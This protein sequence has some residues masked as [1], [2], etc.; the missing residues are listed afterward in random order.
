MIKKL[1]YFAF[2]LI[3]FVLI[4]AIITS[5]NAFFKNI[6]ETLSIWLYYVYPSI[7]TFYILASILISLNIINK[8]ALIF[9]PFISFDTNKAY[10]LFLI[11]I[12]IGNPISSLLTIK[13]L[14]FKKISKNDANKLIQVCSFFN[15][16]FII[17]LFTVNSIL[18]IRYAYIIIIIIFLNNLIF[19][20]IVKNKKS[21]T[22]YNKSNE[23]IFHP[24]KILSSIND[25]LYLLIQVAGV[26]VFVNIIKF[27]IT[28][29]INLIGIKSFI[30]N[31]IISSLEI[32]TGAID[33]LSLQVNT[34]VLISLLTFLLTFQGLSINLQVYNVTKGHYKLMP[35][36]F[37]RFLQATIASTLIY[38]ILII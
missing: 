5:P 16:L 35:I 32:S 34:N 31:F 22:S 8:I 15:P 29:V 11:S 10:E 36:L 33:I 9:K 6:I 14:E 17:S 27:S 18:S 37:M 7:F 26:M 25:C 12:F 13:E 24:E 3:V 2:F 19:S 21:N 38:L 23:I 4:L 1:I 30:I 28:N 20:K